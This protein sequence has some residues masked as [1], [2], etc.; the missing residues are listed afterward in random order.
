MLISGVYGIQ[1][2][3]KGVS[4]TN[5]NPLNSQPLTALQHV[6]WRDAVYD[7]SWQGT[8][9]QIA[10]VSMDGRILKSEKGKF[11]LDAERGHH[12]VVIELE[13]NSSP[14][15]DST[16]VILLPRTNKANFQLIDEKWHAVDGAER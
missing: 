7:F 12:K 11:L 16:F 3:R 8:G 13:P 6:C 14:N 15:P 9:N 5:P 4:I 1:K 2:D 10:K